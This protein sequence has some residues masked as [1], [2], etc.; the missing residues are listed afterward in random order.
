MSEEHKMTKQ[1]KLVLGITPLYFKEASL[2]IC[3]IL[4]VS[5]FLYSLIIEQNW[6]GRSVARCPIP[7]YLKLI[8]QRVQIYHL[9]L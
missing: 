9:Q 1:D 8:K 3:R 2:I 6:K 7:R 4:E 5:V